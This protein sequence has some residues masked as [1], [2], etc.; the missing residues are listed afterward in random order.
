MLH[1]RSSSSPLENGPGN[2]FLDSSVLLRKHLLHLKGHVC[3]LGKSMLYFGAH[4]QSLGDRVCYAFGST[5]KFGPL[6]VKL[7]TF[8]HGKAAEYGH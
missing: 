3:S 5:L 2:F 1:F 8:E 4:V 7:E 6:R